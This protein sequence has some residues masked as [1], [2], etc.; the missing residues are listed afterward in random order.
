MAEKEWVHPVSFYFQ[1]QFHREKKKMSVNFREVSGLKVTRELTDLPRGGDNEN[2]VQVPDT[3][4]HTHVTLKRALEPLD[5]EFT[6]WIKKSIAL[7]EKIETMNM[8]IFLMDDKR[9]AL[10]CW[11][12]GNAYPV[13]W[14][15]SNFDAMKS[16]LAIE[17]LVMAYEYFE[18]KK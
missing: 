15:V 1:V 3:L 14:E 11:F 9:Q 4:S 16:D 17:S 6:A 8:V 5:E 13:T 2:K 10:A 12:C 18:R 7:H